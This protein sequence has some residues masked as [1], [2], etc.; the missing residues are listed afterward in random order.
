MVCSAWFVKTPQRKQESVHS[1]GLSWQPLASRKVNYRV[2]VLPPGLASAPGSRALDHRL[3]SWSFLKGQPGIHEWS[4]RGAY[5]WHLP[6]G[7]HLGLCC[8]NIKSQVLTQARVCSH[9]RAETARAL[10]LNWLRSCVRL[11][12]GGDHEDVP[13]R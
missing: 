8:G 6:P 10:R 11:H 9:R 1:Y 7:S 2:S 4:A 12:P 3:S 13:R 5:I